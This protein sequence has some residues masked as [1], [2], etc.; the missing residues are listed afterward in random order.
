MDWRKLKVKLRG[1]GNEVNGGSAD[2]DRE[3]VPRV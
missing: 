2:N 1:E 3:K